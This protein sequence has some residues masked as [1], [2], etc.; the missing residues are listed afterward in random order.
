MARTGIAIQKQVDFCQLLAD[1][2]ILFQKG[3]NGP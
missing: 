1:R 3:D 2:V